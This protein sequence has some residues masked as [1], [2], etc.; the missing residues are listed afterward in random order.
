VIGLET[1]L[2]AL[3]GHRVEFIVIG[4]IAARIHGSARVTQDLDCVYGRSNENIERLVTALAPF[5]PYPRGAPQG[6]PFQWDV[7][8][9][10]AGLNF[11]L[12]TTAGDVDMLGEVA[13]GGRYEDLVGH[14]EPVEAFGYSVLVISL[15]WL[16]H[17]KRAAGRPRDFEAIAELEILQKLR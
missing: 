14:S 4:G 12:R 10:R 5:Q 7:R 2:A 17:L 1:L 15:P 8:T 11:T 13:G 9:L 6:L 3:H 16:I